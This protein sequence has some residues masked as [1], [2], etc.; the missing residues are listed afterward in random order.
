[1]KNYFKIIIL[2]FII[3]SCVEENPDNKIEISP[4]KDIKFQKIIK[5]IWLMNA[6][7]YNN[8]NTLMLKDS[9]GKATYKLLKDNGVDKYEF[10]KSI[11]FY[12]QNP[13]L[14][15]SIIRDLKDSLEK[16]YNEILDSELIE[17]KNINS[18]DSLKENFKF[19]SRIYNKNT[20]R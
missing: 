14:L 16:A 10:E 3:S 8:N 11:Q 17:K 9:L 1:M 15:D 20:S 5:K 4:L 2:I 18:T 13:I 7:I 6:Y 12:S 19:K